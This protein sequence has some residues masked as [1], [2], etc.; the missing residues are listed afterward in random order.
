[1]DTFTSFRPTKSGTVLAALA[2]LWSTGVALF[3]LFAPTYEG[4][5]ATYTVTPGTPPSEAART[6]VVS[7]PTA[8]EVNGPRIV[9][10][11]GIPILLA[12]L[13]FAFRKQ[14]RAALLGAGLLMLCFCF[15]GALS[16]GI[17]YLPAVALLLL[18]AAATV[19][20]SAQVT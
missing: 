5:V 11:L 1:M 16:V 20:A 17:F 19:P 3:F 8:L 13:P 12:L 18:A 2:V 15:L 14:R 10:A 4:A 7:H 9:F 6:E